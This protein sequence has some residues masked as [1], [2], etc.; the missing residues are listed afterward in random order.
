MSTNCSVTHRFVSTCLWC[1]L[2]SRAFKNKDRKLDQ[3]FNS[4][5]CYIDDV[6]SL[7]NSRFSDYLHRIYAMSL[8]LRILLILKSL[9]L[10]LTFTLVEVIATKIIRSSP[11]SG[12]PLRNI[13]ISNNN[14]SFI[15]LHRCFLSSI[16]VKT[17]T[18]V[19]CLYE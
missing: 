8:K 1:R 12:W 5:F 15:F 10:T 2:P 11:Q 6:L 4:I 3:T 14:G 16:T 17:F 18:G 7:S 19:D 9:L 13:H